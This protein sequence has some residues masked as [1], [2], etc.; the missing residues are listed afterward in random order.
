MTT[1]PGVADPSSS[2]GERLALAVIVIVT[3][4][5]QGWY[6]QRWLLGFDET[7]HFF[8]ATVQPFRQYLSEVRNEVHPPLL[9]VL[10]RPLCWPTESTLLPRVPGIL[11]GLGSVWATHG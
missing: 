11:A 10:L 5:V 7:W 6:A 8:Q 4:C 9:Y 3:L 2:R 1:G